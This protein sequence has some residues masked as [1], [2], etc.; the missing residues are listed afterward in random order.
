MQC[1]RPLYA[2]GFFSRSLEQAKLFTKAVGDRG[3]SLT[4]IHTPYEMIYFHDP[5]SITECKTLVDEH[6]GGESTIDLTHE[7]ATAT[8]P[9]HMRFHGNIS[10][11]LPEKKEKVI[12]T[13]Y[14]AW[15]TWDRKMTLFGR[16]LWD[17]ERYKYIALRVKSDGR[18]YFVNIMVD[19]PIIPTDIH[20]HRL[21][22]R[23][24]GQ[25]E[26]ILIRWKD[27]VRTNHGQSVEPQS[28]MMLQKI[29]SVGIGLTDRVPGPY[30]LCIERI[31]S[32]NG[33]N[34]EEVDQDDRD[35]SHVMIPRREWDAA[36]LKG[37]SLKDVQK[38]KLE[39]VQQKQKTAA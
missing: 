19:A 5:D 15:R 31:W 21:F 36:W 33:L 20:Q 13:G 17:V 30:N 3:E 8:E 12:R 34:E 1:T 4:S 23:R 22:A 2:K 16:A 29:T 28:D 6:I 27:F 24:P 10:L 32:T 25:W 18:K 35:V 14:A 39:G 11:K 37:I 7:K 26:T 38:Q 9:A